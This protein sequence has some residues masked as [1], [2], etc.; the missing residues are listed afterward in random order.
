MRTLGEIIDAVKDGERPDYEE[1][2]YACCALDA[3]LTFDGMAL[4]DLAVAEQNKKK[5]ILVYSAVYQY[6]ERFNRLKIAL[7]TDPKNYIKWDND[8]DNRE[9]LK[10]REKSIKLV[11]KIVNKKKAK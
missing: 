1:L 2:R 8:P 6:K 11:D 4:S 5:P 10:R 7:N 9:Y 3:L